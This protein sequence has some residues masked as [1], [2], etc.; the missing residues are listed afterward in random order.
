M[1]ATRTVKVS[2]AYVRRLIAEEKQIILEHNRYKSMILQEVKSMESKGYTRNQIN[3]GL[4]DLIKSL[5]SGF[6]ETFKYDITL[7]L[8]GKLGMDKSGFL[9]R[10]I[11]NVI[12]NA[13]IMSFKK[14]FTSEGGCHELANLVMDSAAETG[15]EPIIDG[16]IKGLGINPEGRMYATAREAA[17]NAILDGELAQS[18]EDSL[19]DLFCNFEAADIADVFKGSAGG[20]G[21]GAGGVVGGAMDFLGD[22]IGGMF[23]E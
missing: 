17:T 11:A 10:A 16:F 5:G 19:A 6:I 12:E 14:Y 21:G 20:E 22:K 2:P 23:K 15:I 4:M 7:W 8:L 3:E 18:L 9:A 1:T 13:D